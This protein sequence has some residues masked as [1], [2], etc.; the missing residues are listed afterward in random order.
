MLKVIKFYGWEIS[1]R[2][3][4]NKKRSLEMKVLNKIS[5]LGVVSSL[6]WNATPFFV[7]FFYYKIYSNVK[8]IFVSVNKVSALSFGIFIFINKKNQ[9]TAENAFVSL[10]YF[11]ALR[12]YNSDLR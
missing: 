10:S 9:L 12:Y 11:N 7:Y 6:T 5:Y 1:F 3:I 8:F 4:I 2:D